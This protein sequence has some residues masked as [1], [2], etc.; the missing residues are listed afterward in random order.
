[1]PKPEAEAEYKVNAYAYKTVN[2]E[3]FVLIN[4]FANRVEKRDR[5]EY[6]PAGVPQ[7]KENSEYEKDD[8]AEN[9]I[10]CVCEAFKRRVA[11][12]IVDGD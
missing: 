9:R 3:K 8:C 7:F 11:R 4:S 6:Q 12:E 2:P 10:A 5:Q 1:M